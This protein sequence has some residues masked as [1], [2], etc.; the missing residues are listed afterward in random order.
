MEELKGIIEK[1][2]ELAKRSKLIELSKTEGYFN[3]YTEALNYVF[4]E[5][6]NKQE[7]N[8]GEKEPKKDTTKK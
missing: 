4:V 3:G 5:I 2:L 6:L 1:Q 8:Q 7:M